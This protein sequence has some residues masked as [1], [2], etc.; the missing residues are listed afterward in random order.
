[1]QPITSRDGVHIQHNNLARSIEYA[2]KIFTHG[3][4]SETNPVENERKV[5]TFCYSTKNSKCDFILSLRVSLIKYL[6]KCIGT[7]LISFSWVEWLSVKKQMLCLANVQ[8]VSNFHLRTHSHS[9]IFHTR[10]EQKKTL[11]SK[12]ISRDEYIFKMSDLLL[13]ATIFYRTT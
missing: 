8:H 10:K 2:V 5:E 9:Q 1:M 7:K 12:L 4:E 6:E 3:L 13:E 11:S